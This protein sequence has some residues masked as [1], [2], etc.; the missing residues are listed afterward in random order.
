MLNVDKTRLTQEMLQDIEDYE[1]TGEDAIYLLAKK[2]KNYIDIITR[3][4]SSNIDMIAHSGLKTVADWDYI[5]NTNKGVNTDLVAVNNDAGNLK[6]SCYALKDPQNHEIGLRIPLLDTYASKKRSLFGKNPTFA[7]YNQLISKIADV[8]K[9][10]VKEKHVG[11]KHITYKTTKNPVVL[12]KKA[13]YKLL[14][15]CRT[16][17]KKEKVQQ[18]ILFKGKISITN[19]IAPGTSSKYVMSQQEKFTEV[20]DK[21]IYATAKH[22]VKFNKLKMTKKEILAS[23]LYAD[24]LMSRVINYGDSQINNNIENALKLQFS[25][26]LA[27][28]CPSAEK[29]SEISALG[30]KCAIFNLKKLGMSLEDVVKNAKSSGYSFDTEP[31]SFEDALLG[32]K[33]RLQQ[34]QSI[35]LQEQESGKE[36]INDTVAPETQTKIDKGGDSLLE[37]ET[38]LKKDTARKYIDKVI[39]KSLKNYISKSIIEMDGYE[40]KTG[41]VYNKIQR[42]HLFV[43]NMLAYYEKQKGLDLSDLLEDLRK[44]LALGD[45]SD[46]SYARKYSNTLLSMREAIVDSIFQENQYIKKVNNETIISLINKYIGQHYPDSK[47]LSPFINSV[48]KKSLKD[49]DRLKLPNNVSV[50]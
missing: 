47:S 32:S 4:Q 25:N 28:I 48:L 19:N 6:Y 39:A 21:I 40:N 35:N 15:L 46:R 34:K 10:K 27:S 44:E 7:T 50:K 17:F 8:Y 41:K 49:I 12:I 2:K 14:N 20:L 29:L 11:N 13:G 38:L 30:M 1:R 37:T 42:R 43:E 24:I 23:C 33:L 36:Q 18:P 9:I 31:Q 3:M 45:E 26:V 5:R 16:F 22:Y